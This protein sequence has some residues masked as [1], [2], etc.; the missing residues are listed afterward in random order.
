MNQHGYI[1]HEAKKPQVRDALGVSLNVLLLSCSVLVSSSA[2]LACDSVLTFSAF[3][4]FDSLEASWQV[5]R[6]PSLPWDFLVLFSWVEA[7]L[8]G[9]EGTTEATGSSSHPGECGEVHLGSLAAAPVWDRLLP[10]LP[11]G[12]RSRWLLR[13]SLEAPA[14]PKPKGGS[15][16]V[17]RST[18]PPPI[19]PSL[20]FSQPDPTL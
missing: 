12:G 18:P 11:G 13:G 6:R 9:G 2:P 20:P 17:S 4:E 3:E 5:F 8:V 7:G 15:Y 1:I 16:V 19:S 10:G 14:T